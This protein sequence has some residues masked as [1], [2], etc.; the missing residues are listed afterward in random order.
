VI[1]VRGAFACEVLKAG[2]SSNE[3]RSIRQTR[4]DLLHGMHFT[5][6]KPPAEFA[7]LTHALDLLLFRLLHYTG[8]CIDCR[9]W[10]RRT[11]T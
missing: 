7:M 8:L 4:N 9:S 5:T 2:L 3:I 10:Q 1:E 6:T 11:L